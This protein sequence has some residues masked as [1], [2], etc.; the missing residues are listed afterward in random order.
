M[1]SLTFSFCLPL[2]SCASSRCRDNS[3]DH[4][5]GLFT[6]QQLPV[7]KKTWGFQAISRQEPRPHQWSIHVPTAACTKKDMG[8]PSELPAR[9]IIPLP[10]IYLIAASSCWICVSQL[11]QLSMADPLNDGHGHHF[12]SHTAIMAAE[13]PGPHKVFL[14]SGFLLLLSGLPLL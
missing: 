12:S 1:A 2:P 8:I 3:H 9:G 13:T 10:S 4:I 7:Q 14:S 5:N 6:S 11:L